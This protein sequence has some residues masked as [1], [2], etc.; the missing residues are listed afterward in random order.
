MFFKKISRYRSRFLAL[1]V[2]LCGVLNSRC[3]CTRDFE[4]IDA[5]CRSDIIIKFQPVAPEFTSRIEM[6]SVDHGSL[7][8]RTE[9]CTTVY[10]KLEHNVADPPRIS[11]SSVIY[12]KLFSLKRN[13]LPDLQVLVDYTTRYVLISPNLAG[14]TEYRIIS[15]ECTDSKRV[16]YE[17]SDWLTS[18]TLYKAP[19]AKI[20]L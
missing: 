14:I 4:N 16:V 6:S 1:L 9:L 18:L 20:F 12:T 10:T 19:D 5:L 8:P 7:L 13:N 2:A 17:N 3:R 11:G 15:I